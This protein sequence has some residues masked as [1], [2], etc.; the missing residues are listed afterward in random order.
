MRRTGKMEDPAEEMWEAEE[1]PEAENGEADAAPEEV[2]WRSLQ[3]EREY[4]AFWYS[5]LWRLLRPVLIGATVAVIVIGLG[6]SAWGKIYDDYLGPME[7]GSGE[8]VPFSIS[9]GQSL[10]RVAA[11]LE[12]AGLIHSKTVFKSGKFN[13]RIRGSGTATP[14]MLSW[15]S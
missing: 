2:T 12:E 13:A 10:T 9:S 3:K 6:F 15:F 14:T 4:G 1:M 5:A 11:N 8:E 7:P